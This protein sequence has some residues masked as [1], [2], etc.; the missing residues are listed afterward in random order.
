[1]LWP[2]VSSDHALSFLLESWSYIYIHHTWMLYC[3]RH[4]SYFYVSL[5]Y[6]FFFNLYLT[7][8]SS[9]S[10]LFLDYSLSGSLFSFPSFLSLIRE[11]SIWGNTVCSFYFSLELSIS[12]MMF[13]LE[14][15]CSLT[16]SVSL[17]SSLYFI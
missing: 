5:K 3:F 4:A 6:F 15:M 17:G 11:K 7:K 9:L 8:K 13:W 2:G 12:S 10:L 14:A 1:M 16:V